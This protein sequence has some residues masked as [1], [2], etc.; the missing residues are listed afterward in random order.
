MLPPSSVPLDRRCD[1]EGI[2]ENLLDLLALGRHGMGPLWDVPKTNAKFRG[3]YCQ[4]NVAATK[5]RETLHKVLPVG[6][7]PT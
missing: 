7:T 4:K 5:K 6:A 1:L 2:T 3:E